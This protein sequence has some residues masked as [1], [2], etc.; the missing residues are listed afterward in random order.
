MSG[1]GR[2]MAVA[3]A[4]F[5]HFKPVGVFGQLEFRHR[6]VHSFFFFFEQ[7]GH[8]EFRLRAID[9]NRFAVAGNELQRQPAEH[10]VGDGGG[11]A[12]F[13]IF[14]EAARLEPLMREFTDEGFQRHAVLQGNAGERA[15]AVHQ[16]A[17]GRTFLGHRD[18]QF[19]RL[20]VPKQSDRH[21]T[22]MAGN[23]E[24]VRDRRARVRETAAE[25]LAGFDAQSGNFGFK[26]L[27]AGFQR[28]RIGGRSFATTLAGLFGVERLRA[29]RAVTVN[30]HA[31][32]PHLP[33]LNVSVADFL[34]GAFMRHVDGL[35]NGAADERLRGGHHFQVRQ[36]MD[37]ALAAI[38]LEGAIEHRQMLRLEAGT[39]PRRLVAFSRCRRGAHATFLRRAV[40]ATINVFNRVE[41]FDVRDDVF[42]FLR[43]VAETAQRIGHAAID[44]FQHAAAGEELVFYQ[45]DVGFDAGRIAVHQ[46]RDG[47][48]RGEHGDLRV[49][50]AVLAAFGERAFPGFARLVLQIIEF[51]ARLDLFDGV[52]MLLNDAE[53]GFDVVLRQRI[54]HVRATRVAVTRKRADV[55]GN[56]RALLAGVAGHDGR[57]R[58]GERPAFVAVIR[59]TV[60][61]AKRAEVREAEAERAEDVGIFRDVLRRVTGVVHQDFLRGDENAHGGLEPFH[62]KFAVFAFE[63]HQVQRR[64]IARGVVD[65]NVFAARIRGV[66]RLGALA[67]VPFLDRA[68]VLHARVAANPRALGDF[69]EQFRGVLLFERL[70]GGD[71]TRPPFLAGER[72]LHEFIT[73]A[74][75]KVFVL[76]HHT[77]VGVAVVG[78]I[79]ALFNQ[80]PRLLFLLLLGVNEFLDVAVP[81]AQRV[82][83]GRATGFAAGFHD[84]GNLVINFQK[85][86]RAAGPATAAE[87]FPGRADRRKVRAR[88]GAVFEEH[89]FAAGEAHDV[90]HVVRDRLDEAGAALRIFV[91]GGGALDLAR[92]AAVKPVALAGVFADAVLMKQPHV[93]PDRRVERAVLVQAQP[94][95]FL[96]ENLAVRLA[97]IAVRDAPIRNRPGNAMNELA[98]RGLALR[99]V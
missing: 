83:F 2:G 40:A 76:I 18:E 30:R 43:A 39:Q 79:V 23:V 88:A 20:V 48:G 55:R 96:V 6:T 47:A 62:V 8:G 36:I 50:A 69:V 58:A 73:G 91:L 74:H 59:Q 63:L 41:F 51:L 72:R 57:D 10:V 38:R 80:C 3:V 68:V 86:H 22:F 52:A 27:D 78:A 92:L 46:E 45:R 35:G 29:F 64:E 53:H 54:G 32:Q 42:D 66:N 31:F 85:T 28:G 84:I 4:G 87:F 60:A 94:G 37:A 77:A 11:V 5:L 13:G 75:G 95:Q 71:G 56:F 89:R 9:R 44:D 61:H 19:A 21:V 25:R 15:D 24:F 7:P 16:T 81:V 97:E 14:G 65:E 49:A 82:H 90:F 17:D 98:H 99:R 93:E 26:F 12:D 67:G 1:A 33:R 70:A 34:D